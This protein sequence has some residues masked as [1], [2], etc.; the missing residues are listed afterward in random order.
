MAQK[1]NT[2]IIS[3]GDL[4]SIWRIVI[5]N[6]YIPILVTPIFFL[7]GY[8]YIYKLTNVYQASVELLKK[9]DSYYKGNLISDQGAGGFYGTSKSYIDNSNEIRILKSLSIL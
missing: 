9:N 5:K 3:D 8:F 7:V 6:W 4:K 1:K 2:S